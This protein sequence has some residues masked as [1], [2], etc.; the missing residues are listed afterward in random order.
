MIDDIESSTDQDFIKKLI[1]KNG[2]D[3][4][5]D[6]VKAIY[7]DEK[8][9]KKVLSSYP[10]NLRDS[11]VNQ[12]DSNTSTYGD[13]TVSDAQVII[14]PDLYRKIRIGLGTWNFGDEFSDYSDEMA[15]NI[16]ENDPDWQSDPK[17]AKIVS[18]LELYPLKMSYFQ[19]S[20]Q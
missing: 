5:E 3:N 18:K 13:I 9:F 17:K 8:L 14:R 10:K 7:Q 2:F 6:F 11:F 15:Y 16:L 4:V 12:A 19:N 1:E 20:S